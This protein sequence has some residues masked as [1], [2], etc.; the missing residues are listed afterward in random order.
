MEIEEIKM[1]QTPWFFSV[2]EIFEKQNTSINGLT[3]SEANNRLKYFGQNNFINIK[4]ISIFKL[5]IK[6]FMSPLIFI[7]AGAA[8][9]TTFL[10]EWVN[11]IFILGA[12]LINVGLG[13][14]REY[15]AESTLEKLVTY[16]KNR[17][18]VIR[19]NHEKEI[20]SHLLVPGD[21]INLSYGSRIPAD[22]R[23]I[24]VNN[25]RVD[26]AILTG[27]SMPVEKSNNIIK[28][29]SQVADRINMVYA[30]T[31][32]VEGFSTAVVVQTGINTELGKIADLVS[33]TD[34]AITPIQK[35]VSQLSWYIFSLTMFIV[36]CI[37]ILG[38]LRGEPIFQMLVL[39]AAVAVGAVPEALPIALTI[40][41]SVGAERIAKRK[42]IIRKLAAA[43]TLGS[44]TLIM[45][46]KTGTLTK[47]DMKL[48]GVYTYNILVKEEYNEKSHP[49]FSDEQ[50]K[51]LELS[52]R[53]ID[54]AVEN[55][56]DDEKK[57]NFSGRPFEINIAKASILHNISNKEMLLESSNLY[58]PFNSTN[59][60]SISKD[61]NHYIIM[62][63]P[64]ILLEKTDID[65]D[66]YLKV[67]AWIQQASSA[68]KRL[69]AIGTIEGSK[70]IKDINK[71]NN[72]N[73]E[74]ILS[75]FDP[76][77]EEVPEAIKN[78]ENHGVKVI[79]ITGDLKG[80]ALS[81]GKSLGWEVKDDEILTGEDIHQ[82]DDSQIL[83]V[84]NKIK[85]FARVTP[86]DKLRIGSLYRQLGEVVAMTGDGVNDAPA[87][88]MVDIGIS[89]G[90]GSDV[91]QSASD[92]VLLDDNFET[93]S[94][95]IDE[96]RRILANIRKT[97]IYLMSN[98]L[99]QVFVIGGSLI[100]NLALP[101]TALQ[102]IWV[103]LFTGSL[104][105]LAFAYDDNLDK[106]LNKHLN[107]KELLSP[108]VKILSFGLGTLSSF[109][110]FILY[111]ILLR[112]DMDIKI[113]RSIFFVCF[114]IY[115][116][117]IPFSFR[118]L[119][120][121]VFSYNPFSNRNLNIAILI[122]LGLLFI[123]MSLPFM[124]N[125]FDIAIMPA[126]YLWLILVWG[127]FNIILVEFAKWIFRYRLRIYNKKVNNLV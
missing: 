105:A 37:F 76:I 60:F 39:S 38:V 14:Y 63:A 66:E 100:L 78:I 73:F 97:F 43:E 67:S 7:L 96:G 88:K 85:I 33:N 8:I 42:G 46:D 74:G 103:N 2:D 95:A 91:A 94:M 123:T 120:K 9:L 86:E 45:T 26:E 125:L 35:G 57:W 15:Q 31:M 72:I 58:L 34:R 64:D 111:V 30:G 68:G 10:Q 4:S 29:S 27:E 36:V 83:E 127:I 119:N 113:V 114:S 115:I 24:R 3:T 61:H 101:L 104:P 93:I 48:V 99:D 32:V 6:Q 22:A 47:A 18:R 50:K 70:D 40:I 109:L 89:L 17:S 84:I 59:K 54:V 53:N 102:I 79:M 106:G 122:G 77:R 92:L 56:E 20:D 121:S 108:E 107:K 13:L 116:L 51:I 118:S 81:V 65:K 16:I 41:L 71:I 126:K 112:F 21:I 5:A 28:E 62:G 87:L 98:A 55:P 69:I 110:L 44:A 12:I 19:D 1:I 49:H 117:V 11:T 25:F 52:L 80:T 82:M 23:I 124:R 90:S 75:F